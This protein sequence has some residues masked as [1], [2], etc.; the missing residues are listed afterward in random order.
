[1]E[2]LRQL[3]G[4]P[5]SYMNRVLFLYYSGKIQVRCCARFVQPVV[6]CRHPSLIALPLYTW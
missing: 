3:V 6:L 5:A 1:V 4:M 2:N